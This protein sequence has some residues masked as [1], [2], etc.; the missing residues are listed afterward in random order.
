MEAFY[1]SAKAYAHPHII[2]SALGD[3]DTHHMLE[4]LLKLTDDIV[5][6]QFDHPRAATAKALADDFPVQINDNWQKAVDDALTMKERTIF[7]TGSLYFLAKV[8]H[9]LHTKE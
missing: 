9:Y 2:F 8:R 3:K 1:E 6:T 7:I 4:I 5:V